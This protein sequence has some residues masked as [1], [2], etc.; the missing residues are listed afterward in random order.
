MEIRQFG[1]DGPSLPVIGMGTWKTFDVRGAG[2]EGLR[3][4]VVD[5]ALSA[6]T[7]VFD[8]SPMYGEAERVLAAALAGRRE[9]AFVATKIWTPSA[10][11]GRSQ[12]QRAFGLYEGRVD[13]YQIHNLVSWQEH[14]PALEEH[15]TAGRVGLIGTTQYRESGFDELARVIE[16]GRVQAV[17]VPLNPAQR[18]VERE[19]LP[20]AESLGLGV[21][22]MRPL[23]QVEMVGNPPPAAELKPLDRFGVI[24]WAQALLKWV[25]SDRRVHVVIPATSN[26]EHMRENTAAG[27]PPWLDAEARE[28]VG[29]LARQRGFA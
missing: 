20:L 10:A 16:S 21:L 19:I 24:S 1:R 4:E 5:I 27:E 17:Q 7:K 8:S 18:E 3:H 15:R 29:S 25:L 26:P 28:R 13:L 23:G 11:E 9:Q 6:G 22:V 2:A 12:M 14:L